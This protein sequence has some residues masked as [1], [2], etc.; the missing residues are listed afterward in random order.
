MGINKDKIK[1]FSLIELLVVFSIMA[2]LV[3]LL[4]PSMRRLLS[5]N[6]T[7]L[8][9]NK[10]RSVYAGISLY[11]ESNDNTLPGPCYRSQPPRAINN[12]GYVSKNLA[13]YLYPYFDPQTDAWGNKYL[14]ELICPSNQDLEL[15]PSVE[16][17]TQFLVTSKSNYFGYPKTSYSG[18]QKDPKKFN[19]VGTP[20]QTW[21]VTDADRKNAG[22]IKSGDGPDLPLHTDVSRNYLYFDGHI[23]NLIIP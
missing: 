21:A 4:Q 14:N 3:T 23:D 5:H 6:N 22:W 2:I 9:K 1:R 18:A 15:N 11:A 17:R 19:Q 13:G 20:T 12:K 16:S 10:L 8:C 7:N